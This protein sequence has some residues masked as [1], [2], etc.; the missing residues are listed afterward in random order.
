MY[1]YPITKEKFEQIK[2]EVNKL[3][4]EKTARIAGK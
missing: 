4:K 3:H 1:F 2:E